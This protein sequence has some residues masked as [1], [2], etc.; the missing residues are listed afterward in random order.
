MKIKWLFI[1][2]P[3]TASSCSN[4]GMEVLVPESEVTYRVELKLDWS[5]PKFSLPASN[6]HFTWF[7]GMIHQKDSFLWAANGLASE[8]LEFLAEVGSNGRLNNEIDNIISTGKGLSRFGFP[9]PPI[10]G[11]F[12]SSFRFTAQQSCISFASMIAPSPDWF[13]GLN[14]FNLLK[15]NIWMSDVTV[16]LFLYDA[17]TEDGD[18]FGYDNP[19]TSPRQPVGILN[20]AAATVLSNG[21]SALAPIGSLR[22]IKL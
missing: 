7:I 6:P 13:V 19:A 9:S 1:L 21:N 11:G 17:G 3:L 18:V 16:P 14:N 15:D 4:K 2:A 5:T 12:D 8:G 20:A 10:T 22:F